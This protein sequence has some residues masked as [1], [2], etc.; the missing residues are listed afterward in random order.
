MVINEENRLHLA[1]GCYSD[2]L[3]EIHRRRQTD[4]LN[5][6]FAIDPM[7]MILRGKAL[8][9]GYLIH[10]PHVPSVSELVEVFKQMSPDERAAAVARVKSIGAYCKAVEEAA[11]KVKAG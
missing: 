6:Y 7:A 3:N 4:K 2:D 11:A 10:H 5:E 1:E 8:D 9:I